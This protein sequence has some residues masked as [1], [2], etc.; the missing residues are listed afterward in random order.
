MK[1]PT[2]VRLD[3]EDVKLLSELSR[4]LGLS[5]T[6]IIHKAIKLFLTVKTVNLISV[7]SPIVGYLEALNHV[8]T[9]HK[10]QAESLPENHL[11]SD[12]V[13]EWMSIYDKHHSLLTSILKNIQYPYENMVNADK[14]TALRRLALNDVFFTEEL[15]P[16]THSSIIESLKSLVKREDVDM[17]TFYD[18]HR[19]LSKCI[20]FLEALE[21]DVNRL[22]DRVS[23]STMQVEEMGLS[24]IAGCL[25]SLHTD[26][27]DY[28]NLLNDL[29][30]REKH[31]LV[32]S[33]I[34]SL[35]HRYK[36]SREVIREL[37]EKPMK[38]DEIRG[39]AEKFGCGDRELYYYLRDLLSLG[40][41]EYNEE[42]NIY[43]L[44]PNS[45]N[46]LP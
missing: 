24:D 3:E 33:C 43:R 31:L 30:D 41:A 26:L 14:Q 38:P 45:I 34:E 5:R 22:L 37:A 2:S 4:S 35:N 44:S 7:L 40:I 28:I 8:I 9:M 19:R 21:E 1:I 36:F 20:D 17:L 10:R 32:V 29:I 25:N 13:S 23:N 6:N 39:I 15:K 16:L 27:E 12:A 11:I 18:Y 46:M 42:E